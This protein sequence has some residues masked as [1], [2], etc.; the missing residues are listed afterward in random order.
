MKI[1]KHPFV[2]L[3]RP[4]PL[5]A[6]KSSNLNNAEIIL[7]MINADKTAKQLR[8]EAD[9]DEQMS[10]QVCQSN[11]KITESKGE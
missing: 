9:Y 7:N 3:G 5:Q 6:K 2:S 4:F 1:S 8:Q 11:E 10:K